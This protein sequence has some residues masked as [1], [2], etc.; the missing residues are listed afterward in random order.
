MVM[1]LDEIKN[2]PARNPVAKN[3]DKVNRSG[4]HRDK[5]KDYRRSDKHKK[6]YKH[7]KDY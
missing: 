6:D 7:D 1:K 3:M 2:K 4:T 5:K